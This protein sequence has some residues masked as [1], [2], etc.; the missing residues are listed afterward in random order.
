MQKNEVEIIDELIHTFLSEIDYEKSDLDKMKAL[1][2]FK[3]K[4][5]E[6]SLSLMTCLWSKTFLEEIIEDH[7]MQDD[8]FIG[9]VFEGEVSKKRDNIIDRFKKLR[10]SFVKAKPSAKV[11]DILNEAT[12]C[13]VYGFNQ[14]AIALCRA[15]LDYLLKEKLGKKEDEE[16]ELS[17]LIREARKKRLLSSDKMR[18]KAWKVNEIANQVMHARPYGFDTLRIINDTREALEDILEPRPR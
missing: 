11:K 13:Y 3:R 14:A 9:D 12:R 16:H 6:S 8:D 18:Q 2:S 7:I 17:C 15:A 1:S 4:L 5:V 10:K